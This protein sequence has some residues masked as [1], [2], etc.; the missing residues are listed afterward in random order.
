MCG[1]RITPNCSVCAI[2][3]CRWTPALVTMVWVPFKGPKKYFFPEEIRVCVTVLPWLYYL[4]EWRWDWY[5]HQ[6]G[7]CVCWGG[8]LSAFILPKNLQKLRNKGQSLNFEEQWG[9]TKYKMASHCLLPAFMK[10]NQ[11][12]IT[13]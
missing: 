8:F 3:A 9:R 13:A 2:A 1:N 4:L 7:V 6:A 10:W 11:D 12:N 5:E